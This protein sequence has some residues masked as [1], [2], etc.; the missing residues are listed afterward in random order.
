MSCPCLIPVPTYPETAEWGPLVWTILHGLAE[1][2]AQ[3]SIPADEVREWPK[4]LKLTGEMLP[5][6]KCRAHYADYMA[7]SPLT[8]ISTI[9]YTQL[10]TFLKTWL[11][12]LHNDI[13]VTNGKLVFLYADLAVTYGAVNIQDTLWRLEPVMKKAIQLSGVSLMKWTKW[14]HS[15]KMLK[16][17]LG[18]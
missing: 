16:A 3:A 4:F 9:P 11:W 6:E 1:R 13:N 8:Q 18:I 15:C 14:V 12:T 17:I 7:Q 2:S 10:N 5:C